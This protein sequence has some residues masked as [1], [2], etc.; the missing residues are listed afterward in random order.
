M[1]TIKLK[2]TIA[3]V[4][5]ELIIHAGKVEEVLSKELI[6]WA[7]FKIRADWPSTKNTLPSSTLP[8]TNAMDM[9]NITREFTINGTIEYDS[10]T[11][12]TSCGALLAKNTLVQMIRSGGSVTFYYGITDDTTGSGYTPNSNDQYYDNTIPFNAHITR[13]MITETPKGGADLTA[14]HTG[15]AI[16]KIPESY[17]VVITLRVAIEFA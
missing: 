6:A 1:T 13:L 2:K 14:A 9:L 15:Q 11:G 17:D 8:K 5:N 7:D 16:K 3:G 12:A 10:L 4:D